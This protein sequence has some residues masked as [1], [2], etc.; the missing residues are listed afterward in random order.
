MK[1]REIMPKPNK[2]TFIAMSRW[3][4][5]LCLIMCNVQSQTLNRPKGTLLRVVSYNVFHSSVF[6]SDNGS[7][8]PSP[9]NRIENFARMVKSLDADIW[10]LQ[11]VRYSPAQKAALS[12]EGIRKHMQG[13]TGEAWHSSY[14]EP[15]LLILSRHPLIRAD[16][17]AHRVQ[18]VYI[19]LPDSV[20]PRGLYYINVHLAPSNAA[21][22]ALQAE[23]AVSQLRKIR[24]GKDP[25]V[26]ADSDV[27][28][29]GDFNSTIG[30]STYRKI[31]SLDVNV[32]STGNYD[33][34][35]ID[36]VPLQF[37][38]RHT[39][40]IGSVDVSATPPVMNGR[41]IDFMLFGLQEQPLKLLNN[42]IINTVIMDR[43]LLR[44]HGL[45]PEDVALHPSRPLSGT[46]PLDHLPIL[47]DL[48]TNQKQPP[49]M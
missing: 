9:T 49:Q 1:M 24:D 44:N 28:F 16:A 7:P 36:P 47:S 11:E 27:I 10:G 13:I 29:A 19:D 4:I 20:S 6:P 2:S 8:P 37:G 32:P 12:E 45:R 35:L 21:Q 14:V 17:I 46:V 38:T 23:A 31:T 43:T 41:R 39:E 5:L 48:G 3:V 18:G 40:T 30:G 22:Q 26:P 34:K 33:I 42:F 15:G 25:Q